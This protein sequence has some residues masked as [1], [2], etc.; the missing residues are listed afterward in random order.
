MNQ[1]I[2]N[3]KS[4]R[5]IG[6]FND[7]DLFDKAVQ[8]LKDSNID[9]DELYMPLPVHHAVKNVAGSSRLPLLAYILGIT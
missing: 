3:N 9:I 5:Y 7:E 4:E 2:S 1:L 8:S 6:V